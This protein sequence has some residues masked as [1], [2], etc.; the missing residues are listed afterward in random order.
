MPFI[1]SIMCGKIIISTYH[2]TFKPRRL[3]FLRCT[4]DIMNIASIISGNILCANS[5]RP[6]CRSIGCLT[7]RIR[8]QMETPYISASIGIPYRVYWRG[9]R[10][11]C[12]KDFSGNN[13]QTPSRWIGTLDGQSVAKSQRFNDARRS[14]FWPICRGFLRN[15]ARELAQVERRSKWQPRALEKV[16][17]AQ[18]RDASELQLEWSSC[19]SLE[20][21]R[22]CLLS[23]DRPFRTCVRRWLYAI[24]YACNFAAI[25]SEV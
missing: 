2:Q 16:G 18:R 7:I 1:V 13:P 8:H 24:L 23:I 22:N 6:S 25:Q 9:E 4:K 19:C 20:H 15:S 11:K 3:I 14:Y 17:K 12:P 10:C 21:I 5:I